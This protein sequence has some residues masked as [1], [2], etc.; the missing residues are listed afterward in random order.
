MK[1]VKLFWL[2]MAMAFL[3][4]CA[5]PKIDEGV[6]EIAS[7]LPDVPRGNEELTDKNYAVIP[8]FFV[9]DRNEVK[10][11][12]P[13]EMF[14]E[15]RTQKLSYGICEVSIPR[16]IHQTGDTESPNFWKLEFRE[17]P[18]K[19]MVVLSATPKIKNDFFSAI[20]SRINGSEK[21]NAFLF[22]HGFDVSF[23]D[24]ARRT[25]QITYD[26]DFKGAPIFYSWP[27]QGGLLG[28]FTDEQNIEWAEIDLKLF[29]ED[30]LTHNDAQN[31]YLIAHSMGNRAL[32]RA[33]TSV[34]K[35]KP[36]LKEKVKEIILA[37]PDIDADVFKQEIAPGLMASGRHVTLYASS[38]DI[39]LALSK[40]LHGN[41]PR[42][43]D[44]GQGLVIVPGIE[45]IDAT[46]R[47]TGF[48]NHTP[49]EDRSILS[50][51]F[52]LIQ[53]G[54]KADHRFGLE[55]INKSSGYYWKFKQ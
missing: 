26:L 33:I 20:K 37:A 41:Y 4:A 7:T 14:G 29:L 47:D 42:A 30:F 50:D 45:T 25:A 31:I 10:N 18:E 54:Q 19:H 6:F 44:S 39:A 8:T 5:T 55:R 49:F 11:A 16:N 51:M 12:M 43:G 53:N 9:T 28:Y 34:L 40:K 38:D 27:S 36:N 1:A 23:A 17:D 24:A 15:T 32:T 2:I 52:N 22:I 48:W 21:K 3:N 35:D 46:G 13:G